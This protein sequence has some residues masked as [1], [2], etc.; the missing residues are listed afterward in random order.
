MFD[1]RKRLRRLLLLEKE[2]E[3]KPT[4]LDLLKELQLL[5]LMLLGENIEDITP[6]II[7]KIHSQNQKI[8]WAL[9]DEDTGLTIIELL[10]E[11]LKASP[12]E[13]KEEVLKEARKEINKEIRKARVEVNE[14]KIKEVLDRYGK[15]TASD[16][17]IY[18]GKDPKKTERNLDK[19]VKDLKLQKEGDFFSL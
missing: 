14:E 15:L 10:K 9:K 5:R 6:G 8:Y 3:E 18:L 12:P 4:D 16:I 11:N 1:I 17:A 19:M 2:V 13:K 7:T